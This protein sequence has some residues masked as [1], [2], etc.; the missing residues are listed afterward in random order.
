MASQVLLMTNVLVH[1]V[2]K[3]LDDWVTEVDMDLSRLESPK[4][5]QPDVQATPNLKTPL[6]VVN[7]SSS[8]PC[9]RANP[10]DR[11]YTAVSA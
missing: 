6:K 7:G 10:P 5:K 11:D 8:R 9:S 3:R 4:A 1:S 2:N